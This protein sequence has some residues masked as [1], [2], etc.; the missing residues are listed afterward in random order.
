MFKRFFLSGLLCTVLLG[1]P[2]LLSASQNQSESVSASE[3]SELRVKGVV[4]N[5]TGE[6]IPGANVLIKALVAK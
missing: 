2:L 6:T 5:A 3:Q 4:K 1:L